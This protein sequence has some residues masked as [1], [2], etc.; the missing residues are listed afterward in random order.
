MRYIQ[1]DKNGVVIGHFANEQPYAQEC[2]P[3]D[4][5]DILAW[6]AK[7]KANKEEYLKLKAETS[8]TVLFEK[9][10]ALEAEIAALKRA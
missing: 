9:I 5:A 8:P 6:T 2:V 4:H 1:R 3:D 10:K 7:I